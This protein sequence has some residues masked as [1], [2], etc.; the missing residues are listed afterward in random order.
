MELDVRGLVVLATVEAAPRMWFVF[1]VLVELVGV[2]AEQIDIFAVVTLEA[3]K[4]GNKK[5][6]RWIN[7]LCFVT[8]LSHVDNLQQIL[9]QLDHLV[10]DVLVQRQYMAYVFDKLQRWATKLVESAK[11]EREILIRQLTVHFL[12]QTH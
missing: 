8:E 10:R 9:F 7:K 11:L 2:V 4:L 3:N 6:E 12:R 5:T 1:V